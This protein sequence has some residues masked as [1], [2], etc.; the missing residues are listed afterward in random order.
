MQLPPGRELFKMTFCWWFP[1]IRGKLGGKLQS[2][3]FLL[4]VLCVY[5]LSAH[6]RTYMLSAHTRTYT[7]TSA[8]RVC[9]SASAWIGFA[10]IPCPPPIGEGSGNPLQYSC[11]ENSM[12]RRTW[13]A[14]VHGVTRVGH[15][16]ATKPPP[17]PPP[18]HRVRE[19]I[20]MIKGCRC[21]Q[22][23]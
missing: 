12:D 15:V 2:W 21:Y 5:V 20:L 13:W 19:D 3:G 1:A 17:P 7:H 16:L 22:R 23:T 14:A 11:L 10:E 4:T 8:G 18:P 6:T 9:P